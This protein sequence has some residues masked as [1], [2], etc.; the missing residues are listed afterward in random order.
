MNLTSVVLTL[1]NPVDEIKSEKSILRTA[2]ACGPLQRLYAGPGGTRLLVM[3]QRALMHHGQG[4]RACS[5]S[6]SQELNRIIFGKI[7][8]MM[9][10]QQSKA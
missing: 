9:R 6:P 5:K 2:L 3:S 7:P 1:I 8:S 10:I 4:P